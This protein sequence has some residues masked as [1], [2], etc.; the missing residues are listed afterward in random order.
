MF[1][2]WVTLHYSQTTACEQTIPRLEVSTIRPSSILFPQSSAAIMANRPYFKSL[3]GKI[4]SNM[5]A[6]GLIPI[7][8]LGLLVGKGLD[9]LTG[10][11]RL[12]LDTSHDT[13]IDSVV[14]RNLTTASAQIATRLDTFMLERI[15]DA[16]TWASA[17]VVI[18]AAK[19]ALEAHQKAGL[20]GLNIADIE[21]R[22]QDQKSLN[23][24]PQANAYLNQQ[25]AYSAHFGEIFFT[26]RNGFNAALSNK[27]SDFVQSD[28]GWWKSAWEDG[29][30]LG[31]V[32]FDDSAGIWS[33]DISVRIDEPGTNKPLGVMKTVLG[34]SL[35]QEVAT[36]AAKGISQG[37]V[38]VINRDGLLIAETETQHDALRI[39]NP[40]VNLR[41]SNDP[42]M[43]DV[44][45]TDQ[46]EGFALTSESVLGY[47][48]SA[49]AQFYRRAIDRFPGFG[50]T[51]LIT[52]PV[53]DATAP[54]QGLRTRLDASQKQFFTA[55]TIMIAAVAVIGFLLATFLARRMVNQLTILS[56]TAD[57][58]SKGETDQSAKIDSD[59][60]IGDLAVAFER[61]KTSVTVIMRRYNDLKAK[62]NA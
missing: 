52:Q 15:S 13:L 49:G 55:L 25:V 38:T 7:I 20:V 42:Y 6:I 8:V 45:K 21:A 58:I 5:L 39:M 14:G 31:E 3:K 26:D 47:A 54:L 50:W 56:Q 61:M 48:H 23:V 44:F 36:D 57:A 4:A 16:V 19:K 2:A 1:I 22:F 28:E 62:Q 40:N 30:A 9:E 12:Q 37:L 32:E 53:E 35:I 10:S 60:E 33:V 11:M 34:V 51:V 29:I 17:P 59:D 24:S 43:Q 18:D 41:R 27:T 46:G